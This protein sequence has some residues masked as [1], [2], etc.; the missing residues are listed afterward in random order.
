ME[1]YYKNIINLLL[2]LQKKQEMIDQRWGK[3]K[4]YID[5]E[6]K[7]RGSDPEIWEHVK[8]FYYRDD[9]STALPRKWAC[10]SILV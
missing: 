3:Q 4:I 1:N 7:K 9:I 5:F 10:K 2:H 6:Q 8:T